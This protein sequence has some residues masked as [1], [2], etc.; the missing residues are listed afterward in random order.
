MSNWIYGAVLTLILTT[1]ALGIEATDAKREAQA[2]TCKTEQLEKDLKAAQK[3]IDELK[4]AVE[5][6]KKALEGK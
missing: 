3:Q 5:D 1:T 4:K 2:A 6:L